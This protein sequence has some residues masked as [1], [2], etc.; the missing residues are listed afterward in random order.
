MAVGG[1]VG[2]ALGTAVAKAVGSA[3]D[4]GIAV[5]G[6]VAVADGGWVGA[7]VGR[8]V[9]IATPEHPVN[10][11]ARTRRNRLMWIVRECLVIILPE[12]KKRL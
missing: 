3:A 12:N 1:G 6:L 2:V 9:G 11:R 5:T 10:S 7:M 8:G 4:T